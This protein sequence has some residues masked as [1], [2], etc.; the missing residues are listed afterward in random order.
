VTLRDAT[1]PLGR[2][3]IGAGLATIVPALLL[4]DMRRGAIVGS[5]IV[6]AFFGYGHLATMLEEHGQGTDAL[7]AVI[8]AVLLVALA[9]AVFLKRPRIASVTHG[10]DVIAVVLVAMSLV[11]IV[12]HELSRT[13]AASTPVPGRGTPVPGDRDIYW[14]VFD[15]Y[16]SNDSIRR[17]TGVENDLPDWLRGRGFH[18][19]E[20]S[21]ANYVRTTLSLT[22]AHRMDYLTDIGA[23][24]PLGSED[25]GPAYRIVE[26]SRVVTTLRERGYRY[27]N[28]GSWFGPTRTHPLAD[29]VPDIETDT[30]FGAVLDETTV[31]PM[32]R[33]QFW[34]QDE[35]P[36]PEKLH[37]DHGLFQF[38]ALEEIREMPGPKFVFAHILLPHMPYVFDENGDYPD[39][40]DRE[41]SE[42][43]RFADQ[44]TYTNTRIREL[45]G[46]L[47]AG[48]AENRPIVIIQADEG[49]APA[50]YAADLAFDWTYATQ[51]ELHIKFGIISAFYF[52][53]DVGPLP[54]SIGPAN[55]FRLVF[56]RAFGMDL[57][58]LPE[59]SWTSKA[60]KRPWEFTDI[61][62][63]LARP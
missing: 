34:P 3:I 48:P 12:P 9:L 30:D 58:L 23:Q 6:A 38:R 2:A 35:I 40:A 55:T 25:L 63:R 31:V 59:R 37:M 57:A 41:R 62:E 50:R 24:Q 45:V 43:E 4:R 51:D 7:H 61:T 17:F 1:P 16:G 29:Y 53:T 8:I 46:S 20:D 52:P 14:L 28:L 54:D 26:Q 10:L 32:L 60:W 13:V 56:S 36:P 27:V 21:Y 18:V 49:P 15:R 44:L 39:K 33:E 5:A 42:P 11:S 22:T 19:A 47:L